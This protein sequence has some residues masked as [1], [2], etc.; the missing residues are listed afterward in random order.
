MKNDEHQEQA[1]QEGEKDTHGAIKE[2]ENN[3]FDL[4]MKIAKYEEILT[5]IASASEQA[6][7]KHLIDK[8]KTVLT[9]YAEKEYEPTTA[10]EFNEVKEVGK[11]IDDEIAESIWRGTVLHPDYGEEE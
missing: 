6:N 2:L 5:E 10:D 3:N 4:R 1:Y 11:K 9:F 7:P 8:A